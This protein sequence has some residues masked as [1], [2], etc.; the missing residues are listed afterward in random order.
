MYDTAAAL[1]AA[2]VNQSTRA[3]IARCGD[4]ELLVAALEGELNR[5]EGVRQAR[6]DTLRFRID[7]LRVA[8]RRAAPPPAL[9]TPAASAPR[10]ET[11]AAEVLAEVVTPGPVRVLRSQMDE[12]A[13]GL[14]ALDAE[15]LAAE[16]ELARCRVALAGNESRQ[17]VVD[18][19]LEEVA[20]LVREADEWIELLR[21]EHV[22]A[23]GA[24]TGATEALVAS[25][26]MQGSLA[27]ALAA[28]EL[29]MAGK[30]A[31]LNA[32]RADELAAE[33]AWM[34]ATEASDVA[35]ATVLACQAA[36]SAARAHVED[37]AARIRRVTDFGTVFLRAVQSGNQ[38]LIEQLIG[39]LRAHELPDEDL[40]AGFARAGVVRPRGLPPA[41]STVLAATATSTGGR[42]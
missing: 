2:P 33:G 14:R 36:E 30:V 25:E 5:S 32:A 41:T 7:M 15:L 29:D 34:T 10:A 27:T 18:A 19:Q 17:A 16:W 24:L 28:L 21:E 26:D 20:P 39:Q 1:V 31:A 4:L 8:A 11:V 3:W 12:L 22:E 9:F 37:H 6:V 38:P 23:V 13:D 35:G 40:A 42:S